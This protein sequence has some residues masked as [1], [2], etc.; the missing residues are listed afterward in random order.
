MKKTISMKPKS[1]GTPI[2]PDAWVEKRVIEPETK[3]ALKRLTLDLPAPLHGR[4][5]AACAMRGTKMV[6][7]IRSLLE[8]KYG[9]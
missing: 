4:I 5:K 8:D 6:D 9:K 3:E 2:S 1:T 7:E